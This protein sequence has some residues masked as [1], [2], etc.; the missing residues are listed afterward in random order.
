MMHVDGKCSTLITL[1]E[2]SMHTNPYVGLSSH[3]GISRTGVENNKSLF[4][5][6]VVKY[7]DTRRLQLKAMSHIQEKIDRSPGAMPS[8]NQNASTVNVI[9]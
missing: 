1:F 7:Q 9:I 2:E 6:L 3:A 4:R 5:M 8:F